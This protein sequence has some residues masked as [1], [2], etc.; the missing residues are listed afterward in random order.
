MAKQRKQRFE[1]P[2]KVGVHFRLQPAMLR[3]LDSVGEATGL[4]KSHLIRIGVQGV[5]A[6]LGEES[7]DGKQRGH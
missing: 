4:S 7:T 3:E 2:P 1:D 5:V 6:V